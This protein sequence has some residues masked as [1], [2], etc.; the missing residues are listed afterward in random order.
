MYLNFYGLAREPFHVTPDPAYFYLSPSHR[1]AYA[2]VVCG[3]ERRKGFVLITGEVG[4]GK[5]TTLRT[6]L[7][8][9]AD[10]GLRPIYLYNPVLSFDELLVMLLNEAGVEARPSTVA[11]LNQLHWLLLRAYQL[12]R[13]I[14]LVVD[15][16]QNMPV[17]TLEQLRMLSNLETSCDKLIQIVLVGQPELEEKLALR[18]LRQLNQRVALRAVVRPFTRAESAE[19]VNHRIGVA[20]GDT[21]TVFTRRALATLVRAAQGNPRTLNIL[22]D[23]ALMNGFGAALRPVSARIARATIESAEDR[24]GGSRWYR[25]MVE[26]VRGGVSTIN[27]RSA[28]HATKLNLARTITPMAPRGQ[29]Q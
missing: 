12:G 23:T 9:L 13:T 18:E 25:A 8:R 17:E 22:C 5:T 27:R 29:T 6:A 3:I 16:A 26:L 24:A 19:Y 28:I 21:P 1:E 10:S 15:E 4:T 2:S 7:R 14:A 20:G 11:R